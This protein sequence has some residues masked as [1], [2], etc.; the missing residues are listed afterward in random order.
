M[1]TLGVVF[2]VFKGIQPPWADQIIADVGIDS[3]KLIPGSMF[4]ALAG[5]SADGHDFVQDAFNRGASFAL[6]DRPVEDGIRVL[7]LAF[8]GRS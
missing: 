3:R 6:I 7:D 2:E 4:V 8:W 1:I 5:E